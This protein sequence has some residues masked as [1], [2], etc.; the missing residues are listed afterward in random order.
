VT[1]V[2]DGNVAFEEEVWPIEQFS[3]GLAE[4]E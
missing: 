1:V 2:D 3:L 4:E